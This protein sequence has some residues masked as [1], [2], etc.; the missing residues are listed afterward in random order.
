VA[1]P[2][3]AILTHE[4]RAVNSFRQYKSKGKADAKAVEPQRKV[5]AAAVPCHIKSRLF[6]HIFDDY[7]MRY[8]RWT[9]AHMPTR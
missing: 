6:Q 2:R 4:S 3:P 5:K 7:H 9:V 8:W 1:P